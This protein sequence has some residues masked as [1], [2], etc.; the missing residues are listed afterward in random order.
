MSRAIRIPGTSRQKVTTHS[1]L[2]L[3]R[4]SVYLPTASWDQLREI[5]Y[6]ERL[7]G[8]EV[9]QQ[10]IHLASSGA[11]KEKHDKHSTSSK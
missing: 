4:Q 2:E 8:S 7:S 1:G 10:L 9:I 6:A 3:E 11:H 5:C